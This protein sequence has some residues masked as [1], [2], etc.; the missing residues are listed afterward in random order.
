[1]KK[2]HLI[3][4]ITD[5]DLQFSEELGYDCPKPFVHLFGH[6]LFINATE[7]L[8]D[9]VYMNSMS[10]I[11]LRE[12]VDKYHIDETIKEWYPDA[13]FAILDKPGDNIISTCISGLSQLQC[14]ED[15]L[16][17]IDNYTHV[18]TCQS[19]TEYLSS[20]S[21]SANGLLLYKSENPELYH[22]R[23]SDG[24]YSSVA[25]G[26]YGCDAV[27]DAY[28]FKSLKSFVSAAEAMIVKKVGK[29]EMTLPNM[30][31]YLSN[32]RL[33][34][35]DSYLPFGTVEEYNKAVTFPRGTL[36]RTL[37]DGQ[38]FK[39]ELV[40]IAGRDF[41]R[42]SAKTIEGNKRLTYQYD[43][44][45][46]FYAAHKDEQITTPKPL[47]LNDRGG[48]MELNAEYIKGFTLTQLVLKDEFSKAFDTLNKVLLTLKGDKPFEAVTKKVKKRIDSMNSKGADTSSLDGEAFIATPYDAHGDLSLDNIIL[49]NDGKIYLIGF[50]EPIIPCLEVDAAK[51]LKDTYLGWSFRGMNLSNA[52]KEFLDKCTARIY[53]TLPKERLLPWLKLDVLSIYPTT[54]D[55]KAKDFLFAS[56]RTL[57]I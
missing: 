51:L 30:F 40:N 8:M 12:L 25:K 53:D 26:K 11:V 4:L 37:S 23:Y 54:K 45:I 52:Q 22:V 17:L 49:G 42:R 38:Y 13:T 48:Y 9:N 41:S 7:S 24:V 20:K 34:H 19:L 21:E 57:G 16:L 1:M 43:K 33:F 31:N 10:F 50:T 35:L 47:A 29:S 28:V 55:K 27:C 32:V 44:Q 6:P 39:Y 3:Q 15:E 18:F 14:G 56:V 2:L 5:I 46:E 36:L